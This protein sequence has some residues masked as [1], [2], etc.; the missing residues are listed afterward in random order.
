MVAAAREE[1]EVQQVLRRMKAE[2]ALLIAL[3]DVGGVWPI[4][5][6]IELQTR[7][8]DAAVSAA[9]DYLLDDAQRRGKLKR[10]ARARQDLVYIVLAVGKMG[11]GALNYSSDIDL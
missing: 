10:S 3:A 8:A 11:A 2:A 4:S 5:H 1:A 7:V 6:L 9:V